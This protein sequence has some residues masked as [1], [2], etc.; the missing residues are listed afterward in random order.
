M[1]SSL[2]HLAIYFSVTEK[3]TLIILIFQR[4]F[5]IKKKEK[6]KN[7]EKRK[8]KE[9]KEKKKKKKEKKKAK[10]KKK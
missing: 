10:E 3:H 4:Q 7:K 9:K 5:P 6:K 1:L 2:Q 8:T